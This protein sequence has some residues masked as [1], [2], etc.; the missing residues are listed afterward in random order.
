[1]T[2]CSSFLVRRRCYFRIREYTFWELLWHVCKIYA[3]GI[4]RC[5]DA[6]SEMC[7][8][9]AL[10]FHSIVF[11]HFCHFYLHPRS[12]H[13][14]D[15]QRCHPQPIPHRTHHHRHRHYHFSCHHQSSHSECKL[16]RSASWSSKLLPDG[17]SRDRC[18]S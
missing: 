9:A 3:E 13:H 1:M 7:L 5:A 2:T 10:G 18:R 4:Q 8:S 12:R 15:H 11:P 17:T 16:N 6:F 14:H